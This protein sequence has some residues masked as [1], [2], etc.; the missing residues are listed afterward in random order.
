MTDFVT[1]ARSLG[2]VLDQPVL[3]AWTRVPTTDHP[4]KRNGAYRYLGTRGHAMNHATMSEPAYWEHDKQSGGL[5]IDPGVAEAAA[6]RESVRIAQGRVRAAERAAQI[7]RDSV[8]LQHAYLDSKGFK[9]LK[10]LVWSRNGA[11]V[12]VV[13]MRVDG[14]LVG[15]QLIDI[16]GD[17]KFL[18][19]Q[20]CRGATFVIGQGAPIYCEGYATGLSAHAALMA[21]RLRGSVV[22]CFSAHNL[23]LLAKTGIVLA[24]N[25]ASMTGERAAQATGLPYWMSDRVGE[26]FNDFAR[27]VGPFAAS[28]AIKSTLMK[29]RRA[30]VAA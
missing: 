2:L 1:F 6:R 30:G 22:V 15:A 25:D 16:D 29:A 9:E 7:V 4:R 14:R 28:A 23:Q 19:G 10:G 13:P 21:S 24:D 17:K 26:D 5:A 3:G 12:L 18:P 11:P 20:L 8:L 27:R